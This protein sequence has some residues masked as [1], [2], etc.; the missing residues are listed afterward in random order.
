MA[1]LSQLL[2]P[3]SRVAL[4]PAAGLSTVFLHQE[5]ARVQ[6]GGSELQ[7]AVTWW[8]PEGRLFTRPSASEG[9]F[10][11]TSLSGDALSDVLQLV[12]WQYGEQM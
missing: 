10:R 7:P 12:S 6:S 8:D 9:D 3:P 2:L 1:L 4:F 11:G 5:S